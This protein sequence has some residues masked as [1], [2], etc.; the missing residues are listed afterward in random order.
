MFLRKCGGRR[1]AFALAVK[2]FE[3]SIHWR[4]PASC[5][6]T[7]FGGYLPLLVFDSDKYQ[8]LLARGTLLA[9]EI[10]VHRENSASV[11][12]TETLFQATLRGGSVS[13]SSGRGIGIS[14]GYH[15]I[16][17]SWF[18]IGLVGA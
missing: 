2:A 5:L 18:P 10:F 8:L 14:V 6:A 1:G 3:N 9:G 16:C 7:T 13:E 4:S 12:G 11:Y 15:D 17:P